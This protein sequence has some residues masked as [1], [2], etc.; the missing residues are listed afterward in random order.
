ME[1]YGKR[2]R[3]NHGKRKVYFAFFTWTPRFLIRLYITLLAVLFVRM[4]AFG[5]TYSTLKDGAWT[6][7][8]VWST[9][10]ITGC[11]CA[12]SATIDGFDVVINHSVTLTSKIVI[13][14]ANFLT[15]NAE[16][17]LSGAY[18]L[19]VGNDG[20][21]NSSGA[22]SVRKIVVQ[23]GG[24]IN[25]DGPVITTSNLIIDG[26]ATFNSQ[27]I[28]SKLNLITGSESETHFAPNCTITMLN[29]NV[30]NAGVIEFESACVQ[31]S[32][33]NF[34]NSETGKISGTGAITV[35]KGKINNN[36]VWSKNVDWCANGAGKGLPIEE[37]CFGTF[38][39]A[40]APLPIE[41]VFFNCDLIEDIVILKWQTLSESNNDYY[42]VERSV[43][44]QGGFIP[45]RWEEIEIIPGAGNSNTV[46]NYTLLDE[47]SDLYSSPLVIYYRLKQTDY[48]GSY[49]YSQVV[50]VK[51][52]QKITV[53]VYPNPVSGYFTL[54]M[55]LDKPL[56]MNLEIFDVL[57]QRIYREELELAPGEVIQHVDLTGLAKGVYNL[58]LTTYSD[59]T[60]N[61]PIVLD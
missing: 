19:I 43:K 35:L 31:M 51:V 23:P 41:L 15:L 1:R 60:I 24:E 47:V 3:L 37:K 42:T 49:E 39:T 11:K 38:C 26:E 5:I 46:R 8:A 32:G 10:G 57:G 30:L 6:S 45:S 55:Y 12:P 28:V 36:G 52:S 61:K 40:A 20:V 59:G 9:N 34:N 7:T 48:D 17:E 2:Y 50:A 16:S 33:G 4:V 14:S 54:S 58:K 25:F 13:K 53:S 44:E 21:L 27:V 29:G 56:E 22:I 18:D